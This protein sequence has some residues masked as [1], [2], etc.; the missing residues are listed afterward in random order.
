LQCLGSYSRTDGRRISRRRT[1]Y[2]CA[3]D[4]YRRF[5]WIAGR[6]HHHNFALPI[7]N[8]WKITIYHISW[9]VRLDCSW[10]GSANPVAH[11]RFFGVG[12]SYRP[13]SFFSLL[14]RIRAISHLRGIS[15]LT[16]S[17]SVW[18]LIMYSDD[19]VATASVLIL[20]VDSLWAPRIKK[21]RG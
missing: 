6:W 8:R 9:L 17:I 18:A 12:I 19:K 14:R 10:R 13:C 2:A 11:C 21:E 1:D 15:Y 20:I 4:G 5:E 3:F 16:N 7:P